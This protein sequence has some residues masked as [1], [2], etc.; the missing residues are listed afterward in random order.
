MI[1]S[2]WY[3]GIYMGNTIAISDYKLKLNHY[4]QINR[5]LRKMDY[6]INERSKIPNSEWAFILKE[7]Y[8]SYPI[9]IYDM[10]IMKRDLKSIYSK[11]YDSLETDNTL[12]KLIMS[13]D[14]DNTQLSELTNL[15]NNANP[16]LSYLDIALLLNPV[17]Y[18]NIKDYLTQRQKV[19][20][21]NNITELALKLADYYDQ[22]KSLL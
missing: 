8:A 7:P 6:Q 22:H 15:I 5:R 3:K 11:I 18:C 20:N 10:I 12:T 1:R 13:M 19:I 9:T 17:L 16:K 21:A 4:M 14:I 2:R